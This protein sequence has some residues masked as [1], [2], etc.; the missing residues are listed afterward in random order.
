MKKSYIFFLFSIVMLFS[1]CIVK[2]ENLVDVND[3]EDIYFCTKD[4]D[5]LNLVAT[6]IPENNNT[7]KG[8]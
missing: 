5:V 1:A 8:R 7:D 6:E 4:L 2:A 3:D